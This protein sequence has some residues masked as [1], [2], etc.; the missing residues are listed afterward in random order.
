MHQKAQIIVIDGGDNVGK[1][2]QADLLM[3]RLASEGIS[4][5]KFDFPRYTQNTFG[6]LL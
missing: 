2:T 5:G 3:R 4:V 6:H 1:A